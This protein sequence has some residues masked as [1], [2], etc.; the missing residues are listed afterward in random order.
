VAFLIF[1]LLLVPESRAGLPRRADRTRVRVLKRINGVQRA[2]VELDEIV[3]DV[4]A[5]SPGLSE[6]FRPI[7]ASRFKSASF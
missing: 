6:V 7:A 2:R 4:K 3:S 5:S 1:G